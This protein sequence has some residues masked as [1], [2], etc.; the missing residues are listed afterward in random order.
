MLTQ[1][2]AVSLD[3][4][5]SIGR[6]R[7]RSCPDISLTVTPGEKRYMIRDR[8]RLRTACESLGLEAIPWEDQDMSVD[9]P[10]LHSLAGNAWTGTVAMAVTLGLLAHVPFEKALHGAASESD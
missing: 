2:D 5:Q 4:G 10:V 1:P 8:Q 9:I 3:V 7:V 6:Q